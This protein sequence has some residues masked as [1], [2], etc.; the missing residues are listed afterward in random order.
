VA[1]GDAGLAEVVGGHFDVDLVADADADEILAHLAGDV[2]E[3]LMAVGQGHA[4]HGPRQDLGDLAV[5]FDWLFFSHDARIGIRILMLPEHGPSQ[6]G[7]QT[8]PAEGGEIKR[9]F[10]HSGGAGDPKA[11]PGSVGKE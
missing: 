6:A 11:A 8:M 9:K 1:E 2:G 5:Q 3:D 7:G 4:K 10:W